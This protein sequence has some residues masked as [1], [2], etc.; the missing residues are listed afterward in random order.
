[1]SFRN[2]TSL[3]DFFLH[4]GLILSLLV[5]VVLLVFQVWLP[6]T[7]N[8]GETITVPNII[9]DLPEDLER[10]II[11][12]NLRYEINPDSSY[13]PDYPPKAVLQQ[14]PL[15]N[16]KVKENRKIYVTLNAERPPLVRMPKV[17]D[18]SLKSAQMVLKSYDLKLGQIIYVPD[19]FWGVV[20]EARLGG[21]SVLEGE[22]V[23]KGSN[24]D[25]VVGDGYGNTTLQSPFLLGQEQ[26]EAEWVVVGSG[27]KV[28]KVRYTSEPNGYFPTEDSTI[29]EYKSVPPGS[30]QKQEPMPG[31]KLQIG[32]PVYIWVYKPDSISHSTTILD[33]Q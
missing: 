10:N 6:G 16:S 19:I 1:M 25:L 3:K 4:L 23:E 26:E 8:H 17:E 15:P 12:R 20:H 9:G 21:R 29:F 32:D 14:V 28:G 30:V 24:I 18:L 2:P 7:T 11:K 33:N 31:T 5:V 22:R 27:L 13:S